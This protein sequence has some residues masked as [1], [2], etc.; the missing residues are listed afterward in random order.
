MTVLVDYVKYKS[1]VLVLSDYTYIKIG[2]F[3]DSYIFA[4]F[5][6][7][8]EP[9]HVVYC[10]TL[11]LKI[12]TCI[13]TCFLIFHYLLKR[14][15]LYLFLC[16]LYICLCLFFVILFFSIRTPRISIFLKKARKVPELALSYKFNHLNTS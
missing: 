7:Y 11:Y 8:L 14:L 16:I 5:L 15:S 1:R 9:H 12:T 2:N 13:S 4:R 10:D 6:Y 3:L